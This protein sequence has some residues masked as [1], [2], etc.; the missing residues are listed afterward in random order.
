MDDFKERVDFKYYRTLQK[1]VNSLKI[2]IKHWLFLMFNWLLLEEFVKNRQ[3]KI[4][5]ELLK[6]VKFFNLNLALCIGGTIVK[7]FFYKCLSI[8]KNVS[9]I[10]ITNFINSFWKYTKNQISQ[11]T[12]SNNFKINWLNLIS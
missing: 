5:T 12:L 11:W 9:L 10:H 2:F 4:T 3:S 1:K 6:N 8:V 7:S